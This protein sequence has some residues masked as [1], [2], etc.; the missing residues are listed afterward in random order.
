[1]VLEEEIPKFA[2]WIGPALLWYLF[3]SGLVAVF[4]AALAWLA[5]SVLYGPLAAGDRV[6]RGVLTG[7]ADLAG[8]SPRRICSIWASFWE[9][10]T[11]WSVS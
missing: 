5:Q 3:A 7:V 2:T 11:C 4:A 6:Y 10:P 9:P 8:M 1:M